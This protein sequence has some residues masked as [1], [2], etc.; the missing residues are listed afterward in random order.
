M[1]IYLCEAIYLWP[2]EVLDVRIYREAI[3]LWHRLC[4]AIPW[5]RNLPRA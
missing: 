5:R 2:C 3:Y 4:E 1:R